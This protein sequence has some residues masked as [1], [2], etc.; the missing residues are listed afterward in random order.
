MSLTVSVVTGLFTDARVQR[1][2]L[3]WSPDDLGRRT[4][5][6]ER[7]VKE[8]GD[9]GLTISVLASEDER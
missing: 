3:W 5:E 4:L 1:R 9:R 7:E 8:G 2:E 6:G